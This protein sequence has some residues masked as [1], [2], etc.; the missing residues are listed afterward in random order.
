MLDEKDLKKMEE[1]I[2]RLRKL[3]Y[4][5][6]LTGLL[7]RRGFLHEAEREFNFVSNNTTTLERR[8]GFQIPFSVIFLDLDNFKNINDTYG[9]D[10]GD[11]ALKVIGKILNEQLR[12]G[13]MPG[14]LGGEEFVI[15]LVG[16]NI[17]RT[18]VIAEKLRVIIEAHELRSGDK[19]IP[20]TASFGVAEYLED[21][22]NDVQALIK[23]ADDAMYKAKQE[24]KNRIVVA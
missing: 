12:A 18:K 20:L 13:D 6:E 5:D 19:K 1:E 10:V 4:Y 9:H 24:G 11:E 16:A 8:T 3:V 2:D 14:R 21:K 7:N 15:T 17:E 22:D 23:R